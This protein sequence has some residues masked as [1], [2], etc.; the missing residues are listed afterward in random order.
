MDNFETASVDEM[1]EEETIQILFNY[2]Y[3]DK[4]TPFTFQALRQIMINSGKYM[5]NTPLPLRA[6]NL[7]KEVLD[8]WEKDGSR[9]F[10]TE[11]IVN[12]FTKKKIQTSYKNFKEH[13]EFVENIMGN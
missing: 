4:H 11:E 10:I 9:G 5:V 1:N 2:F 3:G 7:A 6:I 12:N 8:F 13:R